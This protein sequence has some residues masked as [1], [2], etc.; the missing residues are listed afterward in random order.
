M[1]K[2]FYEESISHFQKAISLK[3][4]A[5]APR[6]NLGLAYLET[7]RDAEASRA[8]SDLIKIDATYWDAYFQLA[9]VLVKQGDKPTAKNLLETLLKKKPDYRQRAEAEALLAQL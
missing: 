4:D 7:G 9:K 1:R 5:T 2:G 8:F 6:Y 3:A